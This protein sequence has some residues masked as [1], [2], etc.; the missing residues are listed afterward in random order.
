M[1]FQ[2]FMRA[3]EISKNGKRLAA[4]L[5]GAGISSR[6]SVRERLK[7]LSTGSSSV[8]YR[9]SRYKATPSAAARCLMAEQSADL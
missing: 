3:H 7:R 1:V 9:G 4:F 6:P 2:P 8:S 5:L